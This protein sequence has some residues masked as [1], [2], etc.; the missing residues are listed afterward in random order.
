ML[1]DL[2]I[3]PQVLINNRTKSFY[4]VIKKSP[5]QDG[6]SSVFANL[7]Q[8]LEEHTETKADF[9]GTLKSIG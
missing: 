9:A 2:K 8:D 5:S 7:N 3:I 6:L 4:F 1:E